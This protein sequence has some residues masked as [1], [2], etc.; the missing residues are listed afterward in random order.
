MLGRYYQLS[1][2]IANVRTLIHDPS[3]NDYTD[4]ELIPIVNQARSRTAQD[5]RCVR[6]FVTGLNTL[7]QVESYPLTDFVG[8]LVVNSGGVN[9]SATPT[10]DIAGGGTGTAQ[11]QNGNIISAQVNQWT[12]GVITT[13]AVTVTDPTGTGASLTAV[14]GNNIMDLMLITALLSS[15]PASG[16]TLALTFN[17]LPFDA[18]QAFCRAYRATFGWPGAF[19]VHYGPTNPL[20]QQ[21]N[22]QRVYL[23]PIPNQVL[24]MEWDALTLPNDLV[25]LTDADYQ[26]INPWT[27]A[28]RFNAAAECFLGLQQYQQATAM[29]A[30]YD[31]RTKQLPA[32]IRARRVHNFYRR[33]RALVN[34]M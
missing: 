26:V 24:P 34:R 1:D 18:F 21:A 29:G 10:I 3:G 31:L 17:W 33:Y 11:V 6:Q 30:L 14:N 25:N 20:S 12:T 7:T 5:C 27:D 15:P 22:A 4:S 8:G 19:T 32:T 16:A 28:V 13:P 23:F 9:Y 2:Y